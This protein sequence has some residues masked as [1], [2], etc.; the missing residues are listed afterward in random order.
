MFTGIVEEI[1][2]LET[3]RN[4]PDGRVFTI[5]ART[6]L[7]DLRP[8]H[9]VCVDGVCLT[10]TSVSESRFEATAVRETLARSTLGDLNRGIPVNLERALRLSDRLGGHIV[11]GHVDGTGTVEKVVK[12]GTG[13]DVS[14]RLPDAL[15][16][17][18]LEKGSIAVNGIS[19]TIASLGPGRVTVSVIPHTWKQTTMHALK[20]GARV[21][22]E[23]DFLGK[24]VERFILQR[25][26][27]RLDENELRSLGY[28]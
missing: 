2:I 18:A 3:V 5:S 11:Q 25:D 26:R 7:E 22:I 9:S 20:T 28:E 15:G 10:A 4:V 27:S 21:N 1:G 14:I 16:L 19:L 8:D 12:R 23:T 13:Y 17:Y 6:V 24:Y